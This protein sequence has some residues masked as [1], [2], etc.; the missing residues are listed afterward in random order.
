MAQNF[1]SN[2]DPISANGI[3]P[4]PIN[5]LTFS[6]LPVTVPSKVYPQPSAQQMDKFVSTSADSDITPKWK[7]FLFYATLAGLAVYGCK[8]FKFNP[9]KKLLNNKITKSA[10]SYLKKGYDIA[11]T[12]VTTLFKKPSP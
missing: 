1:Y 10:G 2:Y 12:F 9:I 8:K 4:A 7:N 5:T 6:N 3:L 11:K